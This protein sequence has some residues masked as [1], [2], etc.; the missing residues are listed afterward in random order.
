A[1]PVGRPI[2]NA[3][4]YLLDECQQPVPF[5]AAGELYI[6]GM[7]VALGYF[8]RPDMTE[9]RFIADPF[10]ASPQAKLYRTGDLARY[11]PDGNLLYLGRRDQQIKLHGYRIELEEVE[12]QLT[13][14]H[15]VSQAAVGLRDIGGRQHLVAYLVLDF[16]PANITIE[17]VRQELGQRLPE[18][19]CPTQWSVQEIL[20]LTENGKI[21]RKGL[22]QISL[23]E[24]N[25][26]PTRRTAVTVL[27][28]QL[29]EIWQQVLDQDNLG[30]DD[31]FF[32]LGGDS[33]LSLQIVFR[34]REIGLHIAPK[35]LFDYPT[36]A[37]LAAVV[38]PGI[39]ADDKTQPVQGEYA[40]LPIQRAFFEQQP[41]QN[42]ANLHHY[43][44]SYL[45]E[46][47]AGTDIPVLSQALV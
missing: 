26:L 47:E 31:D 15:G 16:P 35:M 21:D 33:I 8:N 32:V 22:E 5:G 11:L 3:R 28:K 44:L 45:Y 27:E 12:A 43:N 1:L 17:N 37:A 41:A 2:A 23:A 14:C 18:H 36:I 30:I 6:G 20:P 10:S 19:M 38:T 13:A 46:L 7:G 39:V 42:N 40:L 24:R 34:A 29:T 25:P 4:L 9:K